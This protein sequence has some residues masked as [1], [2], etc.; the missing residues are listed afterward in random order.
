MPHAKGF[1]KPCSS[2]NPKPTK[3]QRA[4]FAESQTSLSVQQLQNKISNWRNGRNIQNQTAQSQAKEDG[5]SNELQPHI[6]ERDVEDS[7]VSGFAAEEYSGKVP[8][9]RES[10]AG[11]F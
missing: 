10:Y 5:F 7:M 11:V 2:N 3:E 8:V 9:P 1:L 4:H 6:S